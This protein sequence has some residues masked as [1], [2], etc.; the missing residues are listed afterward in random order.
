MVKKAKISGLLKKAKITRFLKNG[1][2]LSKMA[3]KVG[4]R[5]RNAKDTK[6]FQIMTAF[7]VKVS[8]DQ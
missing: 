2:N 7:P 6:Q 5:Q 4:K 1:Q 8:Y 3:T